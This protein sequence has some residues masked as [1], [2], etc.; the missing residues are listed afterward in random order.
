MRRKHKKYITQTFENLEI[1]NS[2]GL[3]QSIARRD[4]LVVFV[5]RAVPGDI[6]DVYIYKEEKKAVWGT[7]VKLHHASPNRVEPFCEH[8]S[9]CGGCKWQ[10]MDYATQLKYKHQQIVDA[11]E[12]TG[13]IPYKELLPII[14]SEHTKYY[15][16]KLQYSYTNKAYMEVFDKDNPDHMGKPALGFHIPNKFDKVFDVNKCHLMHDLHNNMRNFLRDKSLELGYTFYDLRQ[17]TGLMREVMFR[18]TI[19][20][21][22]MVLMVF[23]EPQM[24]AIDKLLQLLHQQF[25]QI[26]SLYYTINQKTNDSYDGLEMIYY[27]GNQFLTETLGDY[28]FKIHPK[29]FFQTN[30]VQ[31]LKLY[32]TTK[33]FAN[34]QGYENVYDLYSGTGT[35]GL[36]VSKHCKQV[37]GIE[38]VQ[39]AVHDAYE[40]ARINDVSN[41]KFFAGDMV[42]VLDEAFVAAHGR[43]DLIIT[44]PPRGGMHPDVVKKIME[45]APKRIVYVSCN[46]ATQVR[47]LALMLDKYDVERVQPVDMFPHTHHVECVTELVLKP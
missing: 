30:P 40:N 36:Y 33:L 21:Q 13:K 38:Y 3:G 2:G 8:Y 44:D 47:D 5:D 12:R 46:P 31:A 42:K 24:E 22:W 32:E 29:S 25:S 4:N 18:N 35:I 14:A 28:K 11:Y 16:N 26:S 10:Q 45:L 6:A 41:A 17:N 34:L 20:G 1:T 37:T 43:P 7:I 15:R 27:S 39:E 23:A 9:I 19:D